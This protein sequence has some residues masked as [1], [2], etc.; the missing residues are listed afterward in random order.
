MLVEEDP[1]TDDTRSAPRYGL[2]RSALRDAI[3]QGRAEP[4]LVLV[5]GPLA[6]LFATSRVPVRQALT[7]LHEEGLIR[8]FEG[9]GYLINPNG[10]DLVPQRLPLTR[11]LLGL[12][13]QE[14][15]ID[16]RPL[17]ERVYDE[18]AACVSTVMV[19]GHYQLDEQRAAEHFGVSRSVV[20]E[21]LMR[22]RDRGL[23]E[24]EP[25]SQWLAGP[26]TAR[27]I[28]EDYEL[29]ALLEPQALQQTAAQLSHQQLQAML[30]RVSLL[31]GDAR[32]ATREAVDRLEQ[33][34]HVHCLAGLR[35]RKMAALIQQ[36]Q[37]PMNVSRIFHDALR[38][39]I[40][41][42]TLVEHRL[43][44]E[45]LLHGNV[46]SAALSLRDHLLRARD[47]T[48]QRLK[49]LSVLPE[50]DLPPYLTRLS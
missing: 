36:C 15:L 46:D 27:E 45:A 38:M 16:L 39:G 14:E 22:L 17:A 34:L 32:H 20:R 12:E 44:I 42:A 13:T 24:K 43:V 10:L 18:I 28:S 31:Q 47:R 26:L 21:A 23:V 11:Q 41:E 19:F 1:I 5:E 7:L 48:L 9:R 2:I 35:N 25:Y 50:P 49:V 33:D 40:D 29:R 30:E 37:S 6:Q 3:L 8:R 4:G